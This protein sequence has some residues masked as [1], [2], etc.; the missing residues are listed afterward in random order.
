MTDLGFRLQ[1]SY[2]G[3]TSTLR[4]FAD[5]AAWIEERKNRFPTKA[6]V[7]EQ[8]E[9][10]R[11]LKAS[12]QAKRQALKESTKPKQPAK[13]VEKQ[14]Q[15]TEVKEEAKSKDGEK[16][17]AVTTE[18]AKSKA[19]L[20]KLRKELRKQEKR[21]AKAEAKASRLESEANKY[22]PGGLVP[23][24]AA[25]ATKI[26]RSESDGPDKELKEI[27]PEVVSQATFTAPT[28][29]PQE[30]RSSNRAGGNDGETDN[31]IESTENED[32]EPN[33]IKLLIDKSPE[34]PLNTSKLTREKAVD[35]STPEKAV[36]ENHDIKPEDVELPIEP[37]TLSLQV[38]SSSIKNGEEA[39]SGVGNLISKDDNASAAST[40]NPLTPISQPSPICKE[41]ELHSEQNP[42][43]HPIES[44]ANRITSALPSAQP[45]SDPQD[46]ILIN[47]DDQSIYSIDSLS[48]TDSE[49][50]ITS[51]SGSSSSSSSSPTPEAQPNRRAP[52]ENGT[53]NNCRENQ[54][55]KNI[56]RSFVNNRGFC[57]KGQ[58]CRY[59]HELPEGRPIGQSKEKNNIIRDQG[60]KNQRVSLYQ[61]VGSYMILPFP[62]VVVA[63]EISNIARSSG[64]K[65][66][67]GGEKAERRICTHKKG[68]GQLSPGERGNT[69]IYWCEILGAL[70]CHPTKLYHQPL[71]GLVVAHDPLYR[72]FLVAILPLFSWCDILLT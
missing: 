1:F 28:S 44:V 29:A 68:R 39:G 71:L 10:Q 45:P 3:R 43:P 2:K 5:I 33:N 61:R 55:A 6:R 22:Q 46:A 54:L 65:A 20:E 12:Q 25:G 27:K 30:D 19:K 35:K 48:T 21:I 51:S 53:P 26:K 72:Y 59:R 60:G 49:D 4:S 9:N 64:D 7:E 11:Q 17:C 14:K 66:G 58:R 67:A 23:P 40:I 70:T 13:P 24:I 34:L 62:C 69:R 57:R 47:Y 8:K 41:E 15:T 42:Q 63:D 52:A 31:R 56:C 38:G 16:E 37:I 32:S 50:A 36:A 18:A